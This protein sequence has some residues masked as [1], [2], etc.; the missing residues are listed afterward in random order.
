MCVCVCLCVNSAFIESWVLYT[1]C[2]V[3]E[4]LNECMQALQVRR[5]HFLSPCQSKI[6][7]LL[8]S[9][10]IKGKALTDWFTD[11]LITNSPTSPVDRSLKFDRFIP[12]SLLTKVNQLSFWNS[13]RNGHNGPSNV[14][15]I[16]LVTGPVRWKGCG[17]TV[18]VQRGM[19]CIVSGIC[20]YLIISYP[21]FLKKRLSAVRRGY[22]RSQ[23]S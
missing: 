5:M 19:H 21:F 1:E 17:S 22:E 23:R 3:I 11:W 14:R 13:T 2:L 15:H 8:T 9:I 20:A 12:C 16:A 7:E 10:L 18:S 4:C 6:L